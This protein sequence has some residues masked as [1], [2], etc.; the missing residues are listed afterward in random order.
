M[1]GG[2]LIVAIRSPAEAD[3]V[4]VAS[5][6]AAAV[7]VVDVADRALR[8]GGR[9]PTT[10]GTPR[11]AKLLGER[12]VAVERVHDHAVDV[13]GHQVR[14]ELALL[15]VT[16]GQEQ[17]ELLAA[18]GERGADAA[19]DLGEERVAEDPRGGLRDE[20]ADRVAAA[21]D[22]GP[23][24]DVGDESEALDRR[25]RPGASSSEFTRGLPLTTRETVAC[26]TPAACATSSIV[27][28]RLLP[29]CLLVIRSAGPHNMPL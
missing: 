12:V 29:P 14:L 9:P 15:L 25:A 7:V 2:P 24:G 1:S 3:Q 8:T 21:G 13:A 16:L 23:G 17:D 10:T 22:E 19:Q 5:M 18:R 11:A 4:L 28:P 20:H 6:P 26:E 27:T